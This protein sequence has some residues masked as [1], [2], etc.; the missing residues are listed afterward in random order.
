M[1]A[2]GNGSKVTPEQLFQAVTGVQTAL[3]KKIDDLARDTLAEQRR[4]GEA[5]VRLTERQTA[6]T[7]L[8]EAHEK[9]IECIHD[10]QNAH[11]LVLHELKDVPD[12]LQGVP[13]GKGS[14]LVDRVNGMDRTMRALINF[15]RPIAIAVVVA[16]LSGVGGFLWALL[17][18]RIAIVEVA[19]KIGGH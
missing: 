19:A 9:E 12:I 18:Q 13:R 10:G 17:T 16:L 14:G 2:R 6:N 8:V 7:A 1:M 5:I 4:Q 11:S 3:G 15:G